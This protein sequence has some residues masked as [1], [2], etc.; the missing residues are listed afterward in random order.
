MPTSEECLTQSNLLFLR[1]LAQAPATN[2]PLENLLKE[3]KGAGFSNYKKPSVESLVYS[4]SLNQHWQHHLKMGGDNCLS[5]SAEQLQSMGVPIQKQDPEARVSRKERPEM[6][7][8]NHRRRDW[9][10]ANRG[11]LPTNLLISY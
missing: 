9:Q 7:W 6:V 11:Q 10:R 3:I 5:E 4:G 8:I 1:D 2:M